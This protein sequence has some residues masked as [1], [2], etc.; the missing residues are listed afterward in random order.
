MLAPAK[1]KFQKDLISAIIEPVLLPSIEGHSRGVHIEGTSIR[2]EPQSSKVSISELL[3]RIVIVLDFLRQY[4]HP[5]IL[6]SLSDTFIPVLSSKII[7]SWLSSAIPTELGGLGEFEK[8]LDKVLEFTN[9]IQSFGWHGHEELVSWVNQAPRLWL[10][11]R[12]VDSL[13]QVRKVLADSEGT[14]KQVERVEVEKV[15]VTD[16][17]LLE[18][19]TSD[20]WDASW[21]DDMV[22]DSKEKP[23]EDKVD[24][25]DVSAWGL[26]EDTNDTETAPGTS[27][28]VHDDDDG[29]AWGWGDED[30]ETSV[31]ASQAK[32]AAK[33]SSINGNGASQHASPREVTLTE[34]YTVTDIPEAILTIIRQQVADSDAITH[35]AYVLCSFTNPNAKS[36]QTLKLARCFL[37]GRSSC[38]SDIDS[39]NVQSYGDLILRP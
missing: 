23:A 28:T 34:R 39:R 5:S 29:D 15:S 2:V 11:R 10:T 1:G 26:D 6:E 31:D 17:A 21:D 3:E 27:A 37:W 33:A 8:T 19:T 32:H 25:E 18:N 7:A 24:E 22:D 16:E 20:D 30:E 4:L 12:R 38:S 36:S 9:T 14:T 35:P 13:D